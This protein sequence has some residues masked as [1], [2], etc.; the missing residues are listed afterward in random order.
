[1][2]EENGHSISEEVQNIVITNTIQEVNTFSI[3]IEIKK[4]PKK[5]A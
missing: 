2:Q 1:M 3:E 4:N 5:Q